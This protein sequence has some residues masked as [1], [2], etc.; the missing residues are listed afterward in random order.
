MI[1][2]MIAWWA[3]NTVAANLL[4]VGIII[5]GLLAYFQM[6]RELDP[7]INFSGLQIRATWPGASPLEVEEQ[8]VSR[9][10]QAL[11]DVD[12]IDFMRSY[13]GEGSGVVWMRALRT[14]DFK[15]FRDQAKQRVDSIA[16]FPPAM[17]PVQI[18]QWTNDYPFMRLRLSGDIGEKQLK[19]LA[20]QV[21]REVQALEHISLTNQFGTRAE[22]IKI[23]LSPE[24]LE[25]YNLSFTEVSNAIRN[26]SLNF[27]SGA[28]RTDV[29]N[30]GLAIRMQ[31]DSEQKFNDIIIRQTADGGTIRLGDIA[32]V[33]DGF[34]DEELLATVNGEATVL[35]NILNSETMQIEKA[36]AEV[37]EYMKERRKTLPEGVSLEVWDDG[38]INFRSN[39]GLLLGS[40]GIGLLLVL[41]VLFLTLRPIVAIW[42]A[43]GVGTAYLG[44]FIFLPGL[45]ISINFISM[46]SFLLVL[47]IVVDD[48]IIVGENIHNECSKTGG[49]LTGAV[50]GAQLVAKPVIYGVL[51]SIIAFLPWIFVN[52]DA[53]EFTRNITWVVVF[54]LTFSLVESLL[55]LPAHLSKMKPRKN[56]NP[57][58]RLQKYVADGI[59]TLAERYYRPIANW[60]SE[61]R[62]TVLMLMIG[63]FVVV[64]FGLR[65]AGYIPFDFDVA[66][67]AD[68]IQITVN[69][70]D[71][72]PYSR[73]EEILRQ[74]Q[75][76]QREFEAEMIA[77]QIVVAQD[78]EGNDIQIID[79]W[80][81]RARASNLM[82]I[83]KLARNEVRPTKLDGSPFSAKELGVR[84]RELIGDIPDAEEVIVNTERGEGNASVQFAI[85]HD[86][87]AMLREATDD[88]MA[89]LRTYDE[90][91]DVR[92]NQSSAIQEAQ[93]TLKPGAVKLGLTLGEVA[94]QVRQAYFGEEPL[95][96][97]RNG[98]DVRVKVLF[99]KETRRDL[100]SLRQFRVLTPTG[101]R[102][103]LE[104]VAD[105]DYAPGISGILHYERKRAIT[106]SAD[107]KTESSSKVL[108]DLNKNYWE[109]FDKA[110]PGVQREGIGQQRGE[111]R[112]LSEIA[113]VYMVAFFAMY[114]LLA[115]AFRSYTQPLLIMVAIPFAYIGALLGH[116]FTGV[117]YTM[118]SIF[119]IAAAAGVV[120]NDNLVMVD[121]CNQLRD[122]GFDA[123]TAMVEAGVRRFRPIFL[124]TLTTVIGLLPMLLERSQEAAF[125]KPIVVALSFGVLFDFFVTLLLVPALYRIG[126]DIK[127]VLWTKPKNFFFWLY[128][129]NRHKKDDT[130]VAE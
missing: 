21:R 4:M 12:G 102:V 53:S 56:K 107:L 26:N 7:K 79:A 19:H 130:V 47:G 76:G 34:E 33:I 88:L 123:K 57:L 128:F 62:W 98:E 120:V 96:L 46:F 115:I 77:N 89:Q 41:G 60:A 122:R 84:L 82:A 118:L 32:N 72:S 78:D 11:S 86:D 116:Y 17:E 24:A 25:Q 110:Y 54:A 29:G 103:P 99:P 92:D 70:P 10:E 42:V 126:I 125:L 121:Y 95:R 90:L 69:M 113:S 80:Y 94:R 48:A 97:P 101:E 74:L 31:A 91:Y 63:S 85:A 127:L 20:D 111:A 64:D 51:T 9:I 40:A 52:G 109:R 55:I 87:F 58:T 36:S 108:E 73:A 3:R 38:A 35:I 49:G 81:T 71:G 50:L 75:E 114:A 67:E 100:E 59:I 124:T 18:R 104:A 37:R 22:E 66:V 2:N 16:T 45:D 106:V 8:I 83:V 61:Q 44:A 14:E 27:S 13:S 117:T 112:F 30:L 28:I 105:V 15:T 93:F 43:G 119:G 6:E 39:L 65:G 129:P 23:E 1:N 68:E 5:A